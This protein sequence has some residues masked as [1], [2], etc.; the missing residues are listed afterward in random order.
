MARDPMT[1]LVVLRH[2]QTD[3][4]AQHR[5]QGFADVPLN[6][7]GIAQAEAA[8]EQLKR[9][10]F[11]AV[12]ASPLSRALRTAEI[13]APG[14]DIQVDRRLMEI[15]VGSWSGQTWDQIIATMPGYE[16]MYA[17]GVDFRRSPTGETLA[18][19]VGRALPAIE[20]IAE[21]HPGQKVLIVSHGL[22]LNRV[23]HAL[24]GLDGR[25]LGGLGN[26]H[27]ST[28]AFDHGAWRLLSHNVGP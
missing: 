28:L 10:R 21:R 9:H 12:Y 24:L 18:E 22:L 13:V 14:A 16:E 25:V 1:N 19:V 6:A 2:G 3:W 27:Y 23:L 4:N 17:N 5:F 8:H 20:E 11:D 15:D 26:A 7:T